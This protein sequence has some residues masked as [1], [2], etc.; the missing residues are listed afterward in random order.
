[1]CLR[2]AILPLPL[3]LVVTIAHAQQAG[4]QNP[5]FELYRNP[6]SG[7]AGALLLNKC[8]GQTWVLVGTNPPRWHPIS[9]SR[10]EFVTP[11]QREA[12]SRT[13]QVVEGLHARNVA[14]VS[15]PPSTP[16]TSS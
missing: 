8:G 14:I 4:Q 10:E 11:P 9:T 6:S 3:L 1:M 12:L 13:A 2:S 16:C 7:I 15:V 5:C